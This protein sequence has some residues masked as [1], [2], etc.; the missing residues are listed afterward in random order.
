MRFAGGTVDVHDAARRT[1]SRLRG[2]TN[3][4]LLRRAGRRGPRARPRAR[5]ALCERSGAPICQ[6]NHA[7]GPSC[8][9]TSTRRPMSSSRRLRWSLAQA[10]WRYCRSAPL[11]RPRATTSMPGCRA[12]SRRRAAVLQSRSAKRHPAEQVIVLDSAGYGPVTI[13]Q[14]V[15]I[16]APAGV[17]AGVS[18]SR[19]RRSDGERGQPST[20]SCC[21]A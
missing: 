13:T 8:A 16:I 14:A 6:V 1:N 5:I 4:S 7:R 11:S 20:P 12:G 3:R 19:G 9:S 18:V 10:R 17:Y 2:R 21:E 15:S